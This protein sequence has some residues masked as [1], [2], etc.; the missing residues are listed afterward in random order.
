M[1]PD[2]YRPTEKERYF[3]TRSGNAQKFWAIRLEDFN[4]KL[5]V[6]FGRV[7]SPG[8]QRTRAFPVP[9]EA[10]MT[11]MKLI[12]TKLAKGYKEAKAPRRGPQ[13]AAAA[14]QAREKRRGVRER[15]LFG[16]WDEFA[17]AVQAGYPRKLARGKDN[18]LDRAWLAKM[19]AA[20]GFAPLPSSYR[21]YLRRFRSTGEWK[22][23]SSMK[24]W[25]A[26]F[27]LIGNRA[28]QRIRAGRE[29]LRSTYERYAPGLARQAAALV[30]FGADGAG[31]Y[32]C[33]YPRETNV[34][35]EP[36]IYVADSRG[37]PSGKFHIRRLG[38]DLFEVITR[39]RYGVD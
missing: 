35:G 9:S 11:G 27:N 23:A 7:G 21:E 2:I 38:A 39:Y 30:P 6:R 5:T 3:Q 26:T 13:F 25:P 14:A 20:C 8:Q 16:D 18:T 1:M 33:W 12:R 29:D 10:I 4:V 15:A 31:T 19:A 28:P 24:G 34:H 36:A 32:F 37:D 17:A 22:L